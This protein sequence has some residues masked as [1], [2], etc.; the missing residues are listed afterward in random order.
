[1]TFKISVQ[2]LTLKANRKLELCPNGTH[3]N[4]QGLQS[5]DQWIK[6]ECG[7]VGILEN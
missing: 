2:L 6:R 1:M 3:S 4:V 7:A 5:L